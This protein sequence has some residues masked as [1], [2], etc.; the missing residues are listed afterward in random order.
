MALA[1]FFKAGPLAM[2]AAFA[3]SG[4][5]LG[6]QVVAIVLLRPGMRSPSGEFVKRWAGGMA[7]RGASFIVVAMVILGA[8]HM[9]PPVWVAAGYLVMLLTLL[10]AETVFLK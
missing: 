7:A 5:A 8:R 3:G 2:A 1:A 4:V 9:L 6:A 10:F